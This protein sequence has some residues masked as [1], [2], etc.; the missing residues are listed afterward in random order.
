ML[1][2][3][4]DEVFDDFFVQN[5]VEALLVDGARQVGKT[6][7]IRAFGRRHFKHLAEVNFIKTPLAKNLFSGVLN[8]SDCFVKLSALVDD[9]I[10][11]GWMVF[12]IVFF[13]KR[14]M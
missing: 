6:S 8:E 3:K 14:Q 1:N 7:S 2:R 10:V 13:P 5:R 12:S 9:D 11:P 4:I